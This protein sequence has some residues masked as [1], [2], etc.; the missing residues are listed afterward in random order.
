MRSAIF[1][2]VNY[3]CTVHTT[4][5]TIH[6]GRTF[7]GDPFVAHR[8]KNAQIQTR[9]GEFNSAKEVSGRIYVKREERFHST[10]CVRVRVCVCLV[11]ATEKATQR[12]AKRPRRKIASGRI[13]FPTAHICT[14]IHMHKKTFHVYAA[15]AAAA[16][17]AIRKW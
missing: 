1:L 14:H 4:S 2:G 9:R 17:T 13:D 12:P 7:A 5:Y 16:A 15:V 6:V 11:C 3:L 8:Q 10:E